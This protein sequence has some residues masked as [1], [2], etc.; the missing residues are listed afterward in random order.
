MH[1]AL[2]EGHNAYLDVTLQLG[3]VGLMLYLICILGTLRYWTASA[4][5]S[6]SIEA[7]MAVGLL[8]FT[9]NHHIAESAMTAPTFPTL[10][11]WCLIASVALTGGDPLTGANSR[12]GESFSAAGGRF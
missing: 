9:L 6:G 2:A 11:L 12:G 3:L 7:A 8:C 1:F 5:R 4:F 10:I